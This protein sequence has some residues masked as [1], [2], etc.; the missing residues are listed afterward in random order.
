MKEEEEDIINDRLLAEADLDD[1]GGGEGQDDDDDDLL[2]V[3][4]VAKRMMEAQ[5]QKEL[6]EKSDTPREMVTPKQRKALTKEDTRSS[7]HTVQ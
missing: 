1:K 7:E 3:E 4:D 2:D 6:E 5:K